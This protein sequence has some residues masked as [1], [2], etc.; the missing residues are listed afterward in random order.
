MTARDCTNYQNLPPAVLYLYFSTLKF[1]FIKLTRIPN[2]S[3]SFGEAEEL[4]DDEPVDVHDEQL[5][6]G[7][8]VLR[9]VQ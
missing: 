1:V 3:P 8:S 6:T 5:S 7:Q 4:S 9:Y 2:Y